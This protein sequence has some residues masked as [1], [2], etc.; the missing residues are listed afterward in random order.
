[1]ST[2]L[3][4]SAPALLPPADK[5]LSDAAIVAG[6][7]GWIGAAAAIVSAAN[8]R[9]ARH[10]GIAAVIY[11]AGGGSLGRG[12]PALVA[13]LKHIFCRV[14]PSEVH[15]SY[16]FPSGHTTAATFVLGAL[17]FVLL[18]ALERADTWTHSKRASAG[19]ELGGS[20]PWLWASGAGLTAAGRVLA[21]AHWLT[22]VLAGGC[23]GVC[24]VAAT[25]LACKASDRA[26]A[27]KGDG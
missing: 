11:A 15:S 2:Q 3:T 4:Q 20:R 7:A 14:R 13:A 19:A 17:L 1:M 21:D 18:P 10:L 5:W 24:L 25:A 23:L 12:D 22:D 6:Y 8:G 27:E 9:A 26:V 16:A